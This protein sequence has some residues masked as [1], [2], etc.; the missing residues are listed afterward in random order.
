M[1]LR[2]TLVN[3]VS[4]LVGARSGQVIPEAEMGVITGALQALAL[5]FPSLAPP[6]PNPDGPLYP[7]PNLPMP[8][9]W[10]QGGNSNTGSDLKS[11]PSPC[12]P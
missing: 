6:Y 5:P 1:G 8:A 11:S 2:D 7:T 4:G 3:A 10:L 9:L 12:E